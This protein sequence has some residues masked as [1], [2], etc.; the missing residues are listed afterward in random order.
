MF[1]NSIRLRTQP[2]EKS[3]KRPL[4]TFKVCQSVPY[5]LLQSPT[6]SLPATCLWLCSGNPST[7]LTPTTHPNQLL[8]PHLQ[9]SPSCYAA[10]PCLPWSHSL[11][12]NYWSKTPFPTRMRTRTGVGLVHLIPSTAHTETTSSDSAWRIRQI[13]VLVLALALTLFSTLHIQLATSK[14]SPECTLLVPCPTPGLWD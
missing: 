3:E 7:N 13:W 11:H 1:R 5:L 8:P 6:A 9:A 12:S 2:L 10:W 4:R 14:T